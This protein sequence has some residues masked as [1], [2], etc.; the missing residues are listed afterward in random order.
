MSKKTWT[1]KQ[2]PRTIAIEVSPSL[3][4][5]VRKVVSLPMYRA[6]QGRP[7]GADAPIASE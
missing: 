5:V 2:I 7:S 1:A 6:K 4:E 3:I